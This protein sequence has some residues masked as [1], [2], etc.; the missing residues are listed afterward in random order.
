MLPLTTAVAV[1]RAGGAEGRGRGRRRLRWRSGHP[2]VAAERL[3][4]RPFPAQPV[5]HLVQPSLDCSVAWL[6]HLFPPP[7]SRCFQIPSA[8]PAVVGA[9]AAGGAAVVVAAAAVG[10]GGGVAVV[11][12]VVGGGNLGGA[13]CCCCCW[14]QSGP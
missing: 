1:T 13:S 9:A 12:A 6:R 8:N 14:V 5:Q 3:Q 2:V 10:G 7:L 4:A 11:A